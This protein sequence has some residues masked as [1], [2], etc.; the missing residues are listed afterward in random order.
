MKHIEL[1]FNKKEDIAEELDAVRKM[2]NVIDDDEH[3]SLHFLTI[4]AYLLT[5]EYTDGYVIIRS[6]EKPHICISIPNKCLWEVCV[7]L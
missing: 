3:E 7:R 2:Y 4:S 1:I 6:V 5:I